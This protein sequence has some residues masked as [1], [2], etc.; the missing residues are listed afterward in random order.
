MKTYKFIIR[1]ECSAQGT[2]K[3]NSKKEAKKA[4]EEG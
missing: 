2:V 1:V 3:A 4:I